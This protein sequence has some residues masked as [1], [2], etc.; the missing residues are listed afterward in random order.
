MRCDH[1]ETS[2]S[3]ADGP[4]DV[5]A[6]PR[7][8]LDELGDSDARA[9]V[10][11]P[12]GVDDDGPPTENERRPTGGQA[13]PAERTRGRRRRLQWAATNDRGSAPIAKRVAVRTTVET[14]HAQHSADAADR[15]Q[16]RR[17]PDQHRQSRERKAFHTLLKAIYPFGAELFLLLLTADGISQPPPAT[18]DSLPRPLLTQRSTYAVSGLL[19]DEYLDLWCRRKVRCSRR[20]RATR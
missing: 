6:S 16:R 20:S 9:S 4:G 17:H 2:D 19:S 1:N 14:K 7:G 13:D 12:Q 10:V 3:R 11:S 15:K 18:R 8:W 5:G